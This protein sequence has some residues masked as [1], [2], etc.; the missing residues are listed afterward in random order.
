LAINPMGQIPAITLDDGR[1]IAQSNAIIR[2]LARQS[3]LLPDDAYMQAKVDELLFWEQYSH[4]PYVAVC[5][6]QMKYQGKP[7][8]EREAWR[9][10]RGEDALDFMNAQLSGKSWFVGQSLSVADI[11]LFAYTRVADEGGF[12]LAPR[13]NLVNW[14]ARCEQELAIAPKH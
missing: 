7:R 6:F 10:Q 8:E 9:V 13:K 2:Y 12:D 3:T 5:R 11:A 1:H 14:I 4:E